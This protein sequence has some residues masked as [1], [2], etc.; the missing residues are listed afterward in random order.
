[1]T[2][3][4]DP[5]HQLSRL[6][7][8]ARRRW[9]TQ[10]VLRGIASAVAVISVLALGAIGFM[11]HLRF[12]PEVV[13]AARLSFF[14]FATLLLAYFCIPLIRRFSD[15]EAAAL[16]ESEHDELDALVVS[17]V[18]ASERTGG[19]SAPSAGLTQ[20]VV[21][22][23]VDNLESHD[24]VGNI[25]RRGIR[26]AVLALAVM[27]GIG[28]ALFVFGPDTLRYGANL[29]VRPTGANVSQNPYAIGVLPG[30]IDVLEGDDQRFAATTTG[31]APSA[32]TL[33]LRELD[34]SGKPRGDWTQKAMSNASSEQE[35]EDF[36][37]NVSR[38]VEYFV[39]AEGVRSST[40]RL[41]VIERPRITR[42]DVMYQFPSYTERAPKLVE[43]N[44]DIKAV[45]GTR[46]E[47]QAYP[48]RPIAAAQLVISGNRIEMKLVDGQLRGSLEL[49]ENAEYF[50]DVPLTN[51]SS[52][53]GSRTY[54]IVALDDQLPEIELVWPRKDEHATSVEELQLEARASDDISVRN[55][56]LVISVNGGDEQVVP[57]AKA[58]ADTPT[59]TSGAHLLALEELSLVPGDLIALYARASDAKDDPERVRSTDIFFVDIRPYERHFRPGPSGGGGGGGQQNEPKLSAQQR[60]LA[61]ALFKLERDRPDQTILHERIALL[62]NAQAK[63][64]DRTDAIARRLG[65]RQVFEKD[66]G[67]AETISA[68]LPKASAAMLKVEAS[69]DARDTKAALPHARTALAH[70]QQAEAALRDIQVARSRNNTGGQGAN[71]LANLFQLEMDKFRNQYEDLQRAK[72]EANAQQLD[73]T[74]R[75]LE[76][77]ARRQSKEVDRAERRAQQGAD[78]AQ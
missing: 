13:G 17:A 37:F 31:F 59:E 57:L 30:D 27:L 16:V 20:R 8:R 26:H 3:Q 60:S 51:G 11:N 70:L 10:R 22:Q 5:S 2:M 52:A 4:S 44:G 33:H 7:S 49:K 68:A 21:R 39:T 29:L 43:N 32:V 48:D 28:S 56:E 24:L 35:F 73:E 63:I 42:V 65:R 38:G 14:G 62:R 41:N 9:H 46:V 45:R 78:S 74:L 6:L 53:S 47:I 12:D 75:Q 40:H 61:V 23:A 76:E 54:Q 66:A 71:D 18:E 25:G 19:N 55:L 67:G 50:I 1:M 15:R 36:M 72:R 64:R 69:L 77:L 58:P 34:S